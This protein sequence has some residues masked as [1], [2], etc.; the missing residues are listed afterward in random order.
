MGIS[1]QQKGILLQSLSFFITHQDLS[2]GGFTLKIEFIGFVYELFIYE[3]IIFITW[4]CNYS[5]FT[6]LG[7]W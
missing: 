7:C 3:I 5:Y 6:R 1:S 2:F 4:L